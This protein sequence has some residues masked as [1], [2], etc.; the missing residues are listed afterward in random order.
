MKLWRSVGAASWIAAMWRLWSFAVNTAVLTNSSSF[1]KICHE[2]RTRRLCWLAVPLD[3][4]CYF[5][6]WATSIS[7]LCERW[8]YFFPPQSPWVCALM[9]ALFLQRHLL[10]FDG[11]VF[12]FQNF[13]LLLYFTVY[14][15]CLCLC[16]SVLQ[17]ESGSESR[18]LFLI[19]K[20]H[21]ES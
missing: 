17:A 15:M 10:M 21:V 3:W 8:T 12:S 5:T 11:C 1:L 9:A 4:L 6:F 16:T 20:R 19:Y 7:A 13:C 14:F 18:L 2:F